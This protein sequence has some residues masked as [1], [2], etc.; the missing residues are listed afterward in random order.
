MAVAGASALGKSDAAC[1]LACAG[2]CALL[3]LALLI[4]NSPS[5][6]I[7]DEGY[8]QAGARMLSRGASF[9]E[10]LTAPLDTPAGP[11]YALVHWLALPVTAL[12]PPQVR[13]VNFGLTIVAWLAI[14]YTLQAWQV[15]RAWA[16]AAM[17]FSVPT[18]WVAG[19]MALTEVPALSMASL[20]LAILARP[21]R[22]AGVSR[23]KVWVSFLAAG[24]LLGFAILARQTYLPAALGLVAIGLFCARLRW[25]AMVATAFLCLLV[26][27]VFMIWGGIVPP[28][29]GRVGGGLYLW[30]GLLAF[31]YFGVLILIL[32]PTYFSSA[33]PVV[34]P[35]VLVGT[36]VGLKLGDLGLMVAAGLSSRLPDPLSAPFQVASAGLLIGGASG[37]VVA[38][39]WHIWHRRN[40]PI[41]VAMTSLTVLLAG[42]AVGIVH[43]FSSRYLLVTLPFLI[44]CIQPFFKPSYWAA[45]RWALGASLGIVLLSNY[46][47][48]SPFRPDCLL[49]EYEVYCPQ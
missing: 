12:E 29:V 38:S 15:D 47:G 39:A 26:G 14:A 41:F 46:Y 8:Y 2:P 18:L 31:G 45:I 9:F 13:W 27:P 19:G 3:A 48:G 28:Y 7:Y 6:L 21:I 4:A 36:V 20:A 44:F 23:N 40:D 16:L 24:V 22:D 33:W 42:T 17:V 5:F 10:M 34:L 49:G 30:H 11:F 25:P 37:V 32:A 43:Q 1:W 35:V